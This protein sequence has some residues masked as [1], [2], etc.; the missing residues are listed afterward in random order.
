MRKKKA[1]IFDVN[2]LL[3]QGKCITKV[4]ALQNYFINCITSFRMIR[5][6]LKLYKYE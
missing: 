1:K 3:L 4:V 6:S 5:T 2:C